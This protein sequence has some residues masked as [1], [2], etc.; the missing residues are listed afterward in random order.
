MKAIPQTS[1]DILESGNFTACGIPREDAFH[2]FRDPISA[3]I[4]WPGML[5]GIYLLSSWYWC[6]DQVRIN[7]CSNWRRCQKMRNSTQKFD[8]VLTQ[9]FVNTDWSSINL[10]TFCL[11]LQPKY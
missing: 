9:K 6:T 3:D 7:H 2:V 4:P 10:L 11:H 8:N 1:L 5:M